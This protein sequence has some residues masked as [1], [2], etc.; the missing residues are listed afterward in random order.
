ME[1]V[2]RQKLDSILREQGIGLG[3]IDVERAKRIGLLAKADYLLTGAVT[4]YES[5]TK[6]VQLGR[7]IP[8]AER[9]RY[10]REYES[11]KAA[12]AAYKEAYVKYVAEFENYAT[13]AYAGNPVGRQ[14]ALQ[15]VR[16][17]GILPEAKSL[18]EI[19]EELLIRGKRSEL[20]TV[21]NIG[22]TLRVFNVTTGAIVWVGQASKRHTSLQ[23]G[24]QILTDKL[25][26]DFLRE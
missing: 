25:V 15:Q 11:Y 14:I 1:V 9:E 21:A 20:A 13:L 19:E 12:A 10:Q 16:Q 24:L 18:E 17:G 6:E 5:I 3:E 8:K 23:E 22:V 7:I 2:E 4:E 26:E